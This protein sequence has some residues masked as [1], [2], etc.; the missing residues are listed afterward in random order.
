MPLY[1]SLGDRVRACLK[2]KIIINKIENKFKQFD[3]DLQAGLEVWKKKCFLLCFF[4]LVLQWKIGKVLKWK[5]QE[6]PGALCRCLGR[7]GWWE[8]PAWS[9]SRLVITVP[10]QTCRQ[11]N[12]ARAY[13]SKS[14]SAG[15]QEKVKPPPAINIRDRSGAVAHACNLSILGARG[16][17]ITWG[18]GLQ[19]SLPNMAKPGLY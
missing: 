6:E 4:F 15:L 13:A 18:W 7:R 10:M 19:T 16:G 8:W 12:G 1:S 11:G 9:D 5:D 17:Q 3:F 2:S 14:L